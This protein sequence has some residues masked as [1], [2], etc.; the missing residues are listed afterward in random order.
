MNAV[1]WTQILQFI[2]RTTKNTKKCK[3]EGDG[4]YKK[5]SISHFIG[6]S[7]EKIFF[8]KGLGNQM[9]R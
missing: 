5:G 3:Q 9:S 2:T 1:D 4:K 6:Q 7:M 8:F